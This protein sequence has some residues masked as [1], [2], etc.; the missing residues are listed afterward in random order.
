MKDKLGRFL[1][2]WRI[3]VVLPHVKGR[4]LDIGCGT[5]KLVRSYIGDGIGVDVYQWEDVDLVVDD[6][7]KLPFRDQEFDTVTIIAA[8]NHIP[9]REE[10]LKEAYRVLRSEGQII[11]TMLPPLIST[12]WHVLRKPWDVDQSERGMKDHE[13][14]GLTRKEI[15]F[16]L[17]NSCFRLSNEERFMLGLNCMITAGKVAVRV[18]PDDELPPNNAMQRIGYRSR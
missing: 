6:S 3:R 8:L 1:L 18:E 11:I 9:N 2:Q 15:H 17:K 7:S 16:L 5:N 12:L 10:V 14:F 13:V 4:L